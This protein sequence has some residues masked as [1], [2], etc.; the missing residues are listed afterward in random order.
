MENNNSE[1][2]KNEQLN[3]KFKKRNET[4]RKVKNG[5]KIFIFLLF[6]IVLIYFLYVIF[7]LIKQPTDIFTIEE[8]KLYQE[9]TDIGYVIRDEVVVKGNNYKNGMEHI[10]NEGEKAT[11]GGNIFRYYSKNEDSLKKQIEELDKEIQI[12]MKNQKDPYSSDVKIIENQLDEEIEK[13]N[14]L[15]DLAKI[16]EHEKKINNLITKKAK[17]VGEKSSSGSHL[18]QLNQ[19]RVELE[20][21]L[22]EGAE[23]IKAPKSGIVSYKVDGLEEMLTPNNFSA[24][25]KSYLENLNLKTGNLIATNNECGKIINNFEAYIA[26]VSNSNNAKEA[27]VGDK[28]KIRLSNNIEIKAEIVYISQENEDEVLL[29]LKI[30]KEI[31]ELSNYRKLSFD[32]IWWSYSGLKVPNQSILEKDG[33]NYVVRNRAGYLSKILVKVKKQNDKYSI[34]SNYNN[35][36]LKELG[37]TSRE[38]SEMKDINIYDE[39]VLNPNLD[40][41]K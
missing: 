19:K 25:S 36:E 13:L 15:N 24:I 23:T 6:F 38:I 7:L 16:T 27:K 37:L 14:K 29:I 26:T 35:E 30:D 17:I 34:I 5:R 39:I 8:G 21:E 11:K 3:K 9:E 18:K 22:N 41:N 31:E 4:S 28:V 1:M 12:A 32:L 33:L 20:K 40:K 2:N 10:K